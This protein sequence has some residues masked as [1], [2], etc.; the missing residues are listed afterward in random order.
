MQVC[1]QPVYDLLPEPPAAS[2]VCVKPAWRVG[3]SAA[4]DSCRNHGQVVECCAYVTGTEWVTGSS[5]GALALWSQLKKKPVAVVRNAH[6][7]GP[8]AGLDTAELRGVS[9]LDPVFDPHLALHASSPSSEC[10]A[11]RP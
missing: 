6:N 2:L 10:P 4:V 9:A 11:Y 7:A 5:D 8:A 1:A 3:S